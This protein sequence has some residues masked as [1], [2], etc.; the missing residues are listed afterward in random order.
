MK[1]KFEISYNELV[2]DRYID[3]ISLRT[4]ED[5]EGSDALVGQERA[6]RAM[7][8]GISINMKG[9]NIYISGD[10]GTGKYYY[11]RKSL[12]RAALNQKVP[13]DLF[14]VYNFK[15]EYEPIVI[16]IRPGMGRVFQHD[17]EY[18]VN[19]I[20]DRIPITFTSEEY[21]RR[22]NDILEEY[23]DNKNKLMDE[24]EAEAALHS[25]QVK[26]TQ[27]GIV[28]TPIVDNRP[29]NENE[30][31]NL[32]KDRRDMI[33][34]E[35]SGIKNKAVEVL[36]K[37]K[38]IEKEIDEKV[39]L[40]DKETGDFTLEDLFL[41]LRQKYADNSKIIQYLDNVKADIIDNLYKFVNGINK[42]GMSKEEEELIQRYQVNLIVD[43]SALK[44]APVIFESNPTYANLIG[45]I[46]YES[47][48]GTMTTNFL[49]IRAGSILRADGGYLILDVDDVIRN[50]QSYESLKRVLKNNQ[51]VIEGIRNQL[52]LLTFSTIKPEPVFA[53]PKV[54]LIGSERTYQLLYEL[55]NEFKELF[56]VKVDFDSYTEK[57]DENIYKTTQLIS[58]YCREKHIRHLDKS[59]VYSVLRYS[60][61]LAGSRRRLSTDLHSIM[62]ILNE[63]NV[64]AEAAGCRYISGEHVKQAVFERNK[65]VSLFEDKML[66]L[67]GDRTIMINTD[68]KAV[69]QVNGLSVIETGG[70][71]FGKPCRITAS[72]YMG[73]SG[74]INIER[75]VQMSGSIHNKGVLILSGYLGERY[76][77]NIPISMT[78]HICFEQLYG[79]VDGD[80]ASAAELYA[81]L[82]SLSGIPFK[83]SIA[84]TGS[85]NQK[86]E[87]QPVGGINEKIEGFHKV[88]T[89]YGLNKKHGV[90][91]P[92]KNIDDLLLAENVTRDIK[93]GLFH[94]Y[95]IKNIDE[96][97]EILAD[98]GSGGKSFDFYVDS[99]LKGFISR[100]NE[101]QDINSGKEN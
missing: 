54:V 96:G 27:N 20:V 86:G 76:A 71:T 48:Q 24:L 22:K 91:I 17:M 75:E 85:L 35:I 87:I 40:L 36:R 101:L 52:E 44:G 69:G 26:S 37:L 16:N 97:I 98:I 46:E 63:S 38:T 43:N 55:D 19:E 61:R 25:I 15:N 3:S 80:S 21:E 47:K 1:S 49:K 83:Q 100:Y 59:G 30:Y 99:R 53:C 60:S 39:N 62:D 56:K 57:N 12:E 13:D 18:T 10:N 93:N 81:L 42:Q 29:M 58:N 50:F 23:H 68:G 66:G 92:Y 94:I 77:K 78:A 5:I 34:K 89:L 28:F 95:A 79:P 72:T 67:Y 45:S 73:K 74:I 41:W 11:A 14:Y 6:E 2:D 7:E 33:L 70:Y 9:Y 90:I 64:W 88:C 51:V 4:T 32:K 65:R 8:F 84:V 31:D 82:S